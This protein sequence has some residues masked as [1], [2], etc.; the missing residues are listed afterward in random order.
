MLQLLEHEYVDVAI[1]GVW[2]RDNIADPIDERRKQLRQAFERYPSAGVGP[3]RLD[4]SALD[5]PDALTSDMDAQL[6]RELELTLWPGGGSR[7]PKRSRSRL[8]DVDHLL[9]HLRSGRDVFV[10]LDR[11]VLDKRGQ[12]RKRFGVRVATPSEVLENLD[13]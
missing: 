9:V 10:T 11:D 12:L 6:A 7:N 13:R 2:W 4:I 1:A 8:T 5:G 3:F